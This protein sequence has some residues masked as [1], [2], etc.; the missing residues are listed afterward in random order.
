MNYDRRTLWPAFESFLVTLW[1]GSLWAIGFIA[2][3]TLFRVLDDRALAGHMFSVV[4]W[5]GMVAGPVLL[6]GNLFVQKSRVRWRYLVVLGMLVLVVVGHFVLQPMI[7]E[8]RA[9]GIPEG[10]SAAAEFGRLHGVASILYVLTCLLGL[11]LVLFT[12][13]DAQ[14]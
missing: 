4:A 10:S 8:L 3:P 14:A 12:R 1:V 13:P 2:A 7:A 11:V 5:L 6:L 9:S